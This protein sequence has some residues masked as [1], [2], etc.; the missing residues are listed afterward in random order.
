MRVHLSA[1]WGAS[2]IAEYELK[3]LHDI[4]GQRLDFK[5]SG[6]LGNETLF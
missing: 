1:T 4:S 2:E 6:Q 3:W 5:A